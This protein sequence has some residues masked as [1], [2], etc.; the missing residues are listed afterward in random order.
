MRKE[1]GANVMCLAGYRQHVA[2]T[3]ATI[4]TTSDTAI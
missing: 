4:Q 3:Q 1:H 2:Q